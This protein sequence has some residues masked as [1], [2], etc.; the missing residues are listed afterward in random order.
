MLATVL[1][2]IQEKH[3]ARLR[4]IAGKFVWAVVLEPYDA[5]VSVPVTRK[6]AEDQADKLNQRIKG[7]E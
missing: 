4:L 6:R 2:A 1:D 5:I 7:W 3:S